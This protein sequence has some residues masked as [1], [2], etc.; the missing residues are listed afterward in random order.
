MPLINEPIGGQPAIADF[1]SPEPFS[2]PRMRNP[3]DI[4]SLLLYLT[5][6]A[7]SC[8]AGPEFVA[9]G[10]LLLGP[11]LQSDMTVA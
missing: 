9:D 5:S 4:T 7:A 11:A 8:V 3:T 2:I 6:A 10:G 1:Y